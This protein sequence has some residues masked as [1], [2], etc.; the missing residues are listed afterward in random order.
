MDR[1]L[2]LVVIQG[3]VAERQGQ[4]LLEPDGFEIAAFARSGPESLPVVDRHRP[5][6]VL[7]DLDP[8]E[9]TSTTAVRC[10]VERF[11]EIP[12]IFLGGSVSPDDITTIFEAGASAYIVKT[13]Q[14]DQLGDA[15]RRAIGMG[16]AGAAFG[17]PA[18]PVLAPGRNERRLADRR[19]TTDRR[20]RV[21][22]AVVVERRTGVD[23]RVRARRR[24]DLKLEPAL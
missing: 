19:A 12:A 11:P 20:T 5:D 18:D 3:H 9:S 16:S 23:R 4:A 6:A 13:T 15:V 1:G 14:L 8:S 7:L 24:D 21:D 2:R 10:L 17:S 22:A